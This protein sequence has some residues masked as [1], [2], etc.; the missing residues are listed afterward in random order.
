MKDKETNPFYSVEF[1]GGPRGW[2]IVLGPTGW[3]HPK[4]LSALLHSRACLCQF[5]PRTAM[6]LIIR[7][8]S[9]FQMLWQ[10]IWFWLCNFHVSSCILERDVTDPWKMRIILK[11]N[12]MSLKLYYSLAKVERSIYTLTKF[13][14]KNKKREKN[15]FGLH[16]K[17]CILYIMYSLL[18]FSTRT[19]VER[20]WLAY[21]K[22]CRIRHSISLESLEIQIP[23]ATEKCR[24]GNCAKD[25]G[26]QCEQLY[27]LS[28]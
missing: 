5:T 10:V 23:E 26:I 1:S 24:K 20:L 22:P 25:S 17:K 15:C 3:R 9:L 27:H 21:P 2:G 14:L 13:V 4:M 16:E 7:L 18:V 28:H 8:E 6:L 12:W 19:S 11:A